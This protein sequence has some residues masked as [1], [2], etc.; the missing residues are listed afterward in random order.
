MGLGA[1]GHHRARDR[2]P[3]EVFVYGLLAW[4]EGLFDAELYVFQE[5]AEDAPA[6]LS[7]R[8]RTSSARVREVSALR[9]GFF[10]RGF[11]LCD[12]CAWNGYCGSFEAGG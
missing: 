7:M 10:R 1:Q 2:S 9:H 5:P 3:H 12:R 6:E 8:V 11:M 4:D